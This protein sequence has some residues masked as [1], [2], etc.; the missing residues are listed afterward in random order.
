[1]DVIQATTRE[2]LKNIYKKYDICN[3]AELQFELGLFIK[4]CIPTS[5]IYFERSYSRFD[6]KPNEKLVK[7]EIDLVIKKSDETLTAIELKYPKNGQV[8]ETMYNFIKDIRFLEQLAES[9]KF[10]RNLFLAIT[11]DE[12]FWDGKPKKPIY[13]YFRCRKYLPKKTPIYK[14]TGPPNKKGISL[15]N[16]YPV[17]WE[18][19]PNSE[20]KL[21]FLLIEVN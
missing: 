13:D 7:K 9:Q 8:P 11:A 5:R 2:F 17:K 21:K 10:H 20:Q 15:N 18:S 4:D 3:E 6:V 19:V 1:M 14:P 12:N 16:S